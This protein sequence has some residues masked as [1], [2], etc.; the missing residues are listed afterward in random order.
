MKSLYKIN[1]SKKI[2]Q[3][4]KEH[5][6]AFIYQNEKYFKTEYLNVPEEID[7]INYDLRL[8]LDTYS[9]FN[10]IK[11]IYENVDGATQDILNILSYVGNNNKIKKIM[12]ETIKQQ[13][14]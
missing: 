13:N 11:N 8:T 6:T 3:T 4:D 12:A 9:D 10:I 2:Q 14:K 1:Q 7:Q 5:V